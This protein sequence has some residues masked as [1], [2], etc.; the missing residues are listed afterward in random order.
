M[1]DLQDPIHGGTYVPFFW[2]YFVEIFPYIG[3]KNRPYIYIDMVGTS[4]ETDPG[5]AIKMM[6]KH[7][8]D[9]SLRHR[10]SKIHIRRDS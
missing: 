8:K 10:P 6:R 4:N 2:P 3:V 9:R 5:M 7:D 1:G